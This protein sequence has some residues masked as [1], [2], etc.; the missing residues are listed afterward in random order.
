MQLLGNAN[1][2]YTDQVT[3]ASSTAANAYYFN[4]IP[5]SILSAKNTSVT[6][7]VASSLLIA[8]P[9]IAGTNQTITNLYPLN[10]ASGISNFSG[11]L[12]LSLTPTTAGIN[13]TTPSALTSSYAMT[14]PTSV[15]SV[16]GRPLVGDTSANL[17]WGPLPIGTIKQTFYSASATYT[18]TTNMVYA[19]IE[20]V[21]G[22][23][24][25]GGSQSGSGV[26]VGGAG[27]G[28]AYASSVLSAATI[29][30]SQTVTIGAGGSGGAAGSNNGAQGGTSSFGSLVN[31]V[32]G[33]GGITNG[34][35][36]GAYD[37]TIGSNGGNSGK[38][39]VVRYGFPGSFSSL[40]G[41]SGVLYGWG[42]M[43]GASGAGTNSGNGYQVGTSSTGSAAPANTGAGG[44]GG[45]STTSANAGGNG[46][47]GYALITEYINA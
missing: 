1:S 11:P 19:M 21:G 25:G 38:G 18:P 46:G 35:L 10:V 36:T 39:V 40:R 42:G 34:S 29:G 31:A 4:Q 44:N 5:Q 13:L 27:G 26:S 14:L 33:F 15:P 32:G 3:A 37:G 20:V 30:S 41:T 12:R 28:G 6:T 43:G 23:G 2:T 17:T 24:G 45:I 22:G 8:G 47:S 16:S 9:P 7:P